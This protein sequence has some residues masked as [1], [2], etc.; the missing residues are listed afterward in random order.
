[1]MALKSCCIPPT[2]A[3][4]LEVITNRLRMIGGMFDLGH[5][6]GIRLRMNFVEISLRVT[7]LRLCYI[8]TY[9]I[10]DITAPS[11]RS[12]RLTPVAENTSGMDVNLQVPLHQ[13]AHLDHSL[14]HTINNK[15]LVNSGGNAMPRD[16]IQ[17]GGG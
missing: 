1:M 2:E 13:E 9:N 7:S 15:S 14:L 4:R 16:L 6:L 12:A 11:Q 10:F 3:R 8:T 5:Y 17:V